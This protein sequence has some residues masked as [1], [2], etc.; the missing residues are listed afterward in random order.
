MHRRPGFAK[1]HGRL[2]SGLTPS[3]H[4]NRLAREC[5]QIVMVARVA[6][7]AALKSRLAPPRPELGR[8]VCKWCRA[9]RD[10]YGR[11]FDALT[12]RELHLESRP[13]A[14]YAVDSL[15]FECGHLSLLE[16]EGQLAIG[17]ASV[18]YQGILDEIE[19]SDYDVFTGRASLNTFAKASRIP[20]VWLKISSV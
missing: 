19:K 13:Q 5:R 9:D 6:D 14:S 8:Q 11:R 2:E 18:F 7:A 3:D 1:E 15:L 10:Q 17:A 16:R 4:R 12:G 20:A